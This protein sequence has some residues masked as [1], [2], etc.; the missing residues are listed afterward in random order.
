MATLVVV[1]KDTLVKIVKQVYLNVFPDSSLNINSIYDHYWNITL[2]C[3]HLS[4]MKT[5]QFFVIRTPD[6]KQEGIICYWIST[7]FFETLKL[8]I[9]WEPM[10]ID[11]RDLNRNKTFHMKKFLH[12]VKT[13][14]LKINKYL[15]I[16][17]SDSHLQI[18]MSVILIHVKTA[19]L[20]QIV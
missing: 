20:A 2:F 19:D 13:L 4:L 11:I 14:K 3:H 10:N 18:L 1:Y 7:H 15:I 8:C 17:F 9:A 6:L 12:L 5:E 16:T